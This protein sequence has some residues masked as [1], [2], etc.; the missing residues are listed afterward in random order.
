MRVIAYVDGFNVYK[1]MTDF[2]SRQPDKL[3]H[4]KINLWYLIENYMLRE[5]ETLQ[6]VRWYSAIP[7]E[8]RHDKEQR[9]VVARHRQYRTDLEST[10][11]TTRISGFKKRVTRCKH[12][13]KTNKTPQEK[14]TDNRL[15]LE[16]L[17]D[18]VFD[19]MD[20]ALLFSSD[21]DFIPALHSISRYSK[22]KRKVDV[23]V[24]PPIG[25]DSSGRNV[26]KTSEQL[27]NNRP[28]YMH[29]SQLKKSL[30]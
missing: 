18:A 27:F 2:L 17:E 24:C 7:N 4:N 3:P 20:R 11:V 5:D 9:E 28:R 15:S 12:C 8:N 6:G 26:I 22:E 23:V 10:G 1:G 30:F 13:K 14:E 21:G 25:R 16:M 29:L 19:R